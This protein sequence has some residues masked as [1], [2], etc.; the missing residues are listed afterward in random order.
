MYAHAR[1]CAL[2][3]AF[4]HAYYLRHM[5]IL[6]ICLYTHARTLTHTHIS[7]TR[8]NTPNSHIY[9]HTRVRAHSYTHT[10]WC[11]KKCEIF[12]LMSNHACTFF[13]NMHRKPIFV[14]VYILL[15]VSRS[16]S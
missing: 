12:I 14:E 13:K 6:S 11:E 5:Y 10:L 15:C 2:T 3:R 9:A 7:C 1:A 16:I 4:T 8:H